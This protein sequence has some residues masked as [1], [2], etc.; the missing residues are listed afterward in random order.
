M[1]KNAKN[2]SSVKKGIANTFGYVGYFFCFLQ[3]LWVA[4]L[5]FSVIQSAI[6]FVSPDANAPVR[7]TPS[8][9]VSLPDPVTTTIV[10]IIVVVMIVVTIYAL[11]RLPM[12]IAKNSNAIVHKASQAAVPLVM[13]AQHKKDTKKNRLALTPKIIMIF[14]LTLIVIPVILAVLSGLTPKLPIDYRIAAIMGYGLA[15][16]S[17]LF[18]GVQ[19]LIAKIFRIAPR[20]LR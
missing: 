6:L 11:I 18:F 8:F 2:N 13:K 5:Y 7:Q 9:A 14:K 10:A 19:Y 3:W 4:L 1:A 16:A 15:G 20:H 17:A 12:N